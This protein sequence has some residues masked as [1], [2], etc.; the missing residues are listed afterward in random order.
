MYL[1]NMNSSITFVGSVVVEVDSD[2]AH[3]PT[4]PDQSLAIS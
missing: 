2:G 1:H 4:G 3:R